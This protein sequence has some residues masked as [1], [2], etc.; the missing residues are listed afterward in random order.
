[1]FWVKP[2][3]C[4]K[5]LKKLRNT[6]HYHWIYYFC[7]LFNVS[8]PWYHDD[9]SR[10]TGLSSIHHHWCFHNYSRSRTILKPFKKKGAAQFVHARSQVH[11]HT[12]KH[13]LSCRFLSPWNRTTISLWTTDHSMSHSKTISLPFS[14]HPSGFFR[15][16]F[17][18]VWEESWEDVGRM[19]GGWWEDDGRM[20]GGW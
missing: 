17:G 7:H 3:W 16:S 13:P 9:T 2:I 5:L 19:L 20:M 6:N 1:M 12:T 10:N 15:D 18:M 11:G 4:A 14:S 8:V